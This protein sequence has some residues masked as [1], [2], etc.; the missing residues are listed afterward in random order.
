MKIKEWMIGI[1]IAALT[2]AGV[3]GA[4]RASTE[5]KV[6]GHEKRITVI[7]EWKAVT[8]R[9]LGGMDAKLDMLLRAN[10]IE[11]PKHR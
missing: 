11:P 1:V 9:Q 4:F 7:E 10:D 3:Y 5:T 6:D 8:D 2:A